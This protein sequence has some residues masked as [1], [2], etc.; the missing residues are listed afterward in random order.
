MLT[1]LQINI[2]WKTSG[3]ALI[4]QL[5]TAVIAIDWM[6]PKSKKKYLHLPI[7]SNQ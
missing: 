7:V 4:F 6:P 3:I 5:A 2:V 1:M